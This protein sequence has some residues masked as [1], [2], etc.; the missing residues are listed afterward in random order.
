MACTTSSRQAGLGG[1][2]GLPAHRG[3]R[4]QAGQP[5]LDAA[6]LDSL[7]TRYRTLAAAGSTANLYRRT[8]AAKDT[9][10]IAR[11]LLRFED[12]ILRFA[13]HPDLGVFPATDLDGAR[14]TAICPAAGAA[15]Q[16]LGVRPVREV[17]PC[18]CRCRGRGAA[19]R[20]AA[21]SSSGW[22]RRRPAMSRASPRSRNAQPPPACP[23][24]GV[25]VSRRAE[26]VV[27]SRSPPDLGKR[28]GPAV[29][30]ADARYGSACTWPAPGRYGGT[31]VP[32]RRARPGP[33]LA[34]F[35]RPDCDYAARPGDA[36]RRPWSWAGQRC[37]LR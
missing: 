37:G 34:A 5:A 30:L 22:Q 25:A 2:D 26:T 14:L 33:V 4:R 16:R 7:V 21:R 17:S 27:R 15:G 35:C 13:A 36:L 10:R 6:V 31:R 3:A 9:R 20:S 11:R 29:C 23:A 24:H 28:P 19:V 18:G 32:L 1:A 12:L 8:A